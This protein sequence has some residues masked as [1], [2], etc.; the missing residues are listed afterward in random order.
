METLCTTPAIDGCVGSC[1]DGCCAVVEDCLSCSA[2]C[3]LCPDMGVADVI[4]LGA[5]T[6]DL[7]IEAAVD[8]SVDPVVDLGPDL[9][10]EDGDV[11]PDVGATA[12]TATDAGR[13]GPLAPDGHEGLGDTGV[14]P[15]SCGC[16]LG[17][18]PS[19]LALV[20]LLFLLLLRRSKRAGS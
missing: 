19:S 1:G 13:D 18:R 2:D 16:G 9:G 12:D 6:D 20:T 8:L 5:E 4:D 3:G 15:G 7:R 14:S 11:A 17:R 10:T